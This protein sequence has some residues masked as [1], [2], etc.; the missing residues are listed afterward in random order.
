MR[1]A[2][3]ALAALV[4]VAALGAGCSGDDD[5]GDDLG[6]ALAT[7]TS[8]GPAGSAPTQY[9]RDLCDLVYSWRGELAEGVERLSREGVPEPPPV[10]H[11]LALDVVADL[12][13]ATRTFADDVRNLGA[14]DDPEVGPAVEQEVTEGAAAAVAELEAASARLDELGDADFEDLVYRGAELAASLEKASSYV[15]QRLEILASEHGVTGPNEIC[16]FGRLVD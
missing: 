9:D 6:G 5:T 13:V 16:G 15:T 8:G 14:P 7:T 1:R 3:A 11:E 10:R 12:V 2:G 4:A